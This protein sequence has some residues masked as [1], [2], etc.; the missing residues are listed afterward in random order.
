MSINVT[1]EELFTLIGKLKVEIDKKNAIIA[2]QA[3]ALE[4]LRNPEEDD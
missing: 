3:A 2:A 4:E 1:T